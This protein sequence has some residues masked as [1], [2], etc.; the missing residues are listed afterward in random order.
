MANLKRV[1]RLVLWLCVGLMLGGTFTLAH[2]DTTPVYFAGYAWNPTKGS[3]IYSSVTAA[4]TAAV[5]ATFGSGYV[6]TLYMDGMVCKINLGTVATIGPMYTCPAGG[7]LVSGGGPGTNLSTDQCTGVPSCVAPAVRDSV[8]GICTG[9]SCPAAGSYGSGGAA[10]DTTMTGSGAMPNSLCIAGCSYSVGGLGVGIGTGASAS[11]AVGVGSSLGSTCTGNTAASVVPPDDPKTKCLQAGQAFGTVNGQVV[12]VPAS[13]V[14]SQKTTTQTPGSNSTN[15]A[16]TTNVTNTTSCT[17]DGSC[18]TTTTTTTTSGGSGPGGTGPGS[19]TKADT[20]A[21]TD[22]KATFCSE[23]PNSP[24][25]KD[26]SFAG[27]CAA[28]AAPAC[29]GDAVQCAQ[30]TAAWQIKCDVETEPTDAAYTLGKSLSSGGADPVSDPLSAANTTNTDIG[31]MIGTAG[32]V[33]T[34]TASCIPSPSFTVMGHSYS[35]D[36]TLFCN[37]ASIVGYLM[38]AAASVIAVRM[39]TSGAT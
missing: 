7:S 18:T 23:N 1:M 37:F 20:V 34:L 29:T 36:T 32:G 6:S 21:T 28:G 3:T 33:R 17:G 22:P 16:S 5:T 38:V 9:P 27:S 31:V 19:T 10:K 12:C 30:A 26:S 4:C 13:S 14:S 8:T 24:M 11:W 2:A 25:C 15:P 35:M 39:V